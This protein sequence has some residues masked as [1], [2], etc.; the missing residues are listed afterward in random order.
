MRRT[1]FTGGFTM[2]KR[3][4]ILYTTGILVVLLIAVGTL[5]A[6]A[7]ILTDF[8]RG[9]NWGDVVDLITEDNINK[10]D[11]D[12]MTPLMLAVSIGDVDIAV[13]LVE[14]GADVNKVGKKETISNS[15]LAIASWRGDDAM[16]SILLD[17]DARDPWLSN[18]PDYDPYG[19]KPYTFGDVDIDIH[20]GFIEALLNDNTTPTISRSW[21]DPN[22]HG[23]CGS[24]ISRNIFTGGPD[25]GQDNKRSRSFNYSDGVLIEELVTYPSYVTN[26][27]IVFPQNV[28][29]IDEGGP[30]V[31][32][33][34]EEHT[35]RVK[36]ISVNNAGQYIELVNTDRG[37]YTGTIG[38]I[39]ECETLLIEMHK[40]NG[41]VIA[42]YEIVCELRGAV[43]G[44]V[45]IQ[46]TRWPGNSGNRN[47]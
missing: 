27:G 32:I 13:R 3:T 29:Q 16:I 28:Y 30:F 31:N 42:E 47:N 36:S 26:Q 14:S 6:N 2:K 46:M 23:P 5:V 18:V 45:T 21:F 11:D 19:L 20:P 35:Q 33:R 34:C 38:Q 43:P 40:Q 4:K 39:D 17:Y 1:L 12:G 37:I 25:F 22:I 44:A 7:S 15:P 24:T 10:A 41:S 8:I 9:G